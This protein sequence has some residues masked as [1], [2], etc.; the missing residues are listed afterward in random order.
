VAA[1][2]WQCGRD[3][4]R[5]IRSPVF[6]K[7]LAWAVGLHALW[8]SAGLIGGTMLVLTASA[9]LSVWQ[10]RKLLANQGYRT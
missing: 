3:F 4:K 2:F 10:F 9:S 5:A 6:L 7:A 1:A 8:D